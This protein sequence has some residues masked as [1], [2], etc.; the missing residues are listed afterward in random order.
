M[1]MALQRRNVE[2]S[3]FTP[4]EQDA[5]C[6]LCVDNDSDSRVVIGF[7]VNIISE[8]SIFSRVPIL[9]GWFGDGRH[10]YAITRLQKRKANENEQVACTSKWKVLDS[11][12]EE[13]VFVN[14]DSEI[15]SHLYR[16]VEDGGNVFRATIAI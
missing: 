1:Q 12:Y 3:W 9:R 10:W 15:L 5:D 11:M 14:S 8:K 2:L 16:I 7:I 4:K 13:P 6:L